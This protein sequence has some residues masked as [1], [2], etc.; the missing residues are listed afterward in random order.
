MLI[1]SDDATSNTAL[2]NFFLSRYISLNRENSSEFKSNR[3]N[4]EVVIVIDNASYA[5]HVS[6]S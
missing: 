1:K 3:N 2:E 4:V 5:A 6:Y